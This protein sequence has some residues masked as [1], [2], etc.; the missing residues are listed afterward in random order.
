MNDKLFYFVLLGVALVAGYF[1][2]RKLAKRSVNR[3]I[4]FIIYLGGALAFLIGNVLSGQDHRFRSLAI[5][6]LFIEVTAIAST[7]R[8]RTIREYSVDFWAQRKHR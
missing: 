7:S 2:G 1:A 6:G 8:K 3:F 4:G 5:I